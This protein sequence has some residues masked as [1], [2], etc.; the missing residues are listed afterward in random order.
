LA[1]ALAYGLPEGHYV[2]FGLYAALVFFVV[3]LFIWLPGVLALLALEWL[4]RA[5]RRVRT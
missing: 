2:G 4:F 5:Y 1:G 3:F